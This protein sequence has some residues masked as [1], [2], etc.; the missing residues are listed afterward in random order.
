MTKLG[1]SRHETKEVW[2]EL[3]VWNPCPKGLIA[4]QVQAIQFGPTR[5][6][7]AHELR[8]KL[9]KKDM[10]PCITLNDKTCHVWKG[11]ERYES[12]IRDQRVGCCFL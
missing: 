10:Y 11:K 12:V 5:L 4:K 2:Y 3:D 9:E 7:L 8:T 1:T 6:H